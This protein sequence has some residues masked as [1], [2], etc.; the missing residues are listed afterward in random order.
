MTVSNA[1][2]SATVRHIGPAVSWL[3][4]IGI[5]PVRGTRPRV[6]LIPTMPHVD[7]GQITEPSVSVPTP[8]AARLAAIAAPVPD[9]EPHGLRSSMYGLCVCP[10][11]PDQPLEECSERKFAHSLRFVLPSNTA[12]AARSCC[13][14]KESC[15]GGGASAR[16]RLPAVVFILSAVSRL[17]FTSTGIPWS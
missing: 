17:S 11:R 9:D 7:E 1:A 2:A 6:G 16:P 3:C 13:T 12:P 4:A 10:P 8:I 5:I 14:T 15:F